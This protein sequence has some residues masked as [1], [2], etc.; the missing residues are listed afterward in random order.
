V[1]LK[2]PQTD[3]WSEIYVKNELG[4]FD[5]ET[6]IMK[7]ANKRKKLSWKKIQKVLIKIYEQNGTI[8]KL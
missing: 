5:K 4:H 3:V 8:Q 7:T 2:H 6:F 1:I